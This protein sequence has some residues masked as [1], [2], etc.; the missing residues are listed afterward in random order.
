MKLVVYGPERRVGALVGDQ[1]VDLNR[2]YAKYL[3][4]KQGEARAAA[5]A[6]AL[7]PAQLVGLVEGGP[8][9]LEAAQQALDY[10]A[11]AKDPAGV[12]GATVSRSASSVQLHA[13]VPGPSSRIACGGAN[14]AKH[15]AGMRR[16]QGMEV[17][18]QE[19]FEAA[20]KDGQWGFWK[21]S[22]PILGPEGNREFLVHLAPGPSCA[23]VGGRCLKR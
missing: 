11:S 13:P 15:S 21:I 9:A 20:R 16:N 2:A 22:Q 4:E 7:V 18:E 1:V 23:E 8:R 12:G 14:F 5:Q 17:T 6:D 10:V 3:Q 19:V